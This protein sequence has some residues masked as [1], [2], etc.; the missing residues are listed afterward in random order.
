M[1]RPGGLLHCAHRAGKDLFD[2]ETLSLQLPD[3][4]IFPDEVTRTYDKEC[5]FVAFE[6][7]FNDLRHV[8][9]SIGEQFLADIRGIPQLR[10][11]EGVQTAGISR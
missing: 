7:T 1:R 2:L 10:G 5:G 4:A 3:D 8:R 6:M 9:V 11:D